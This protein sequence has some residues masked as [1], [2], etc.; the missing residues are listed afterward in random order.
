MLRPQ[1]AAFTGLLT[2]ASISLESRVL[3]H[4]VLRLWPGRAV[5]PQS[6]W[7]HGCCDISIA[8]RSYK[9]N[10]ASISLESR[11]LRQVG[12][13]TN[14]SMGLPPQ[15]LWNHG[16]CDPVG[17]L[18]VTLARAASI[19]LESRVLRPTSPRASPRSLARLNLFGI[20]G[21]AT[22]VV[23]TGQGCGLPPQSL[24]NHGCCDERVRVSSFRSWS[25]PQ[26]LWNHG[27]CDGEAQ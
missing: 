22:G 17:R 14:Q 21:A 20:T 12:D 8:G 13:S 6:L 23:G 3:R 24:W 2:T 4:G 10:A 11:V 16:C 25:P 26:S 7:N 9:V 1:E 18:R 27:C 19:S 15:S 5:P